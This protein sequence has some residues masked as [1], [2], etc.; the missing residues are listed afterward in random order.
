[1]FIQCGIFFFIGI[2]DERAREALKSIGQDGAVD[3][4]WLEEG[5]EFEEEDYNAV[6]ARMRGTAAPWRQII[7]STNPREELHWINRRLIIGG[8]AS[9]YEARTEQNPYNP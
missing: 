3:I 9:S 1:M 2:K 7:V 5:V 8:E 4:A 6:I